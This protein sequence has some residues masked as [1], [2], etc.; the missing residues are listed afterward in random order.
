MAWTRS[1]GVGRRRRRRRFVCTRMACVVGG[2]GPEERRSEGDGEKRQRRRRRA[3]RRGG[4]FRR[5][6]VRGARCAVVLGKERKRKEKKRERMAC[7]E[8]AWRR[9]QEVVVRFGESERKGVHQR[10]LCCA[11][12]NDFFLPILCPFFVFSF[13]FSIPLTSELSPFSRLFLNSLCGTQLEFKGL[14]F[15]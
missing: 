8:E 1:D 9:Q 12:P 5:T 13:L 4:A 3:L 6:Q 10:T 7:G 14:S 2:L 15:L 11:R